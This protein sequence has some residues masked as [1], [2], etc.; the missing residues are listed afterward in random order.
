MKCAKCGHDMKTFVHQGV[1]IDQCTECSGIW[2]DKGEYDKMLKVS[3][4]KDLKI[5]NN[6]HFDYDHKRAHCP[7]CGGEKLMMQVPSV[8]PDIHMDKC[9]QCG[10]I[11]LDGGEFEELHLDEVMDMLEKLF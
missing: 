11:W 2:F 9:S 10:G 6:E 8:N 3:D 4:I 7:R 5:K 1:E